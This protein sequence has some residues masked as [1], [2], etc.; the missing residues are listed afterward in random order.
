M[1]IQ[2]VSPS[3]ISYEASYTAEPKGLMKNYSVE[4]KFCK[5]ETF[6][7]SLEVNAGVF[8]LNPAPIGT[9]KIAHDFFIKAS[10]DNLLF[11]LD[12]DKWS[13]FTDIFTGSFGFT[14]NVTDEFPVLHGLLVANLR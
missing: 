6:P 10:E 13:E 9:A 1:S 11:S 14:A 5:G 12:G 2:R 3:T 8:Q 7:V 4:K